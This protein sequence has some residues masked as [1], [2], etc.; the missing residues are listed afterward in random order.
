M[1]PPVNIFYKVKVKQLKDV[2]CCDAAPKGR[3]L[4]FVPF[5]S[6]TKTW[7]VVVSRWEK[8]NAIKKKKNTPKQI[9][10]CAVPPN[11]QVSTFRNP[12]WSFRSHIYITCQYLFLEKQRTIKGKIQAEQSVKSWCKGIGTRLDSSNYQTPSYISL[13]GYIV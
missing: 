5:K 4:F 3:Q 8:E 13:I 1:Q 2:V 10:S 7:T 11:L 12:T 6:K 9:K